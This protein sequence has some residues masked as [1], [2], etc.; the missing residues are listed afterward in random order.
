MLL[1]D[2]MDIAAVS[3]QLDA[4]VKEAE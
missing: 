3:R 1:A 2:R 4:A